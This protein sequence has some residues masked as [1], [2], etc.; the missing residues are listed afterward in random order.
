MDQLYILESGIKRKAEKH[1]CEYCGQE[2][3]R[4]KKCF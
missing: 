2:F 4:R 3:I 1:I